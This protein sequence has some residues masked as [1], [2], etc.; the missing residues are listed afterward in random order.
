MTTATRFSGPAIVYLL[1]GVFFLALGLILDTTDVTESAR[2]FLRVSGRVAMLL[3]FI[4]FGASALHRI[5]HAQWSHYLL[6]NRR[7]FGI[8]T[9]ILSFA[10]GRGQRWCTW[11]LHNLDR[12]TAV[13]PILTRR[14]KWRST[15]RATA[16]L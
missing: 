8:S 13:K 1:S 14:S 15:L 7:Y 10:P 2:L 16:S 3:L 12:G 4:S 5:F 9:G 11:I 6:Q